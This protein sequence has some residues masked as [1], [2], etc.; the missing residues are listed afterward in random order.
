MFSHTVSTGMVNGLHE[1][2]L[3]N[4]ERLRVP[5][6]SRLCTQFINC[7]SK[8][9]PNQGFDSFDEDTPEGQGA[10]R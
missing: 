1:S 3:G 2:M 9:N 4:R 6:V 10:L 7:P 5:Y 8:H